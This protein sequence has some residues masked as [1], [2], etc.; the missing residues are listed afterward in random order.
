MMVHINPKTIAGRPSTIS[1]ELMLT[2]LICEQ[3]LE[4][5]NSML[6]YTGLQFTTHMN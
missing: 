5:N 4:L 2:N 6:V 1:V 3:K